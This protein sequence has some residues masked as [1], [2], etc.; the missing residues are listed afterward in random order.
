MIFSSNI[1]TDVMVQT[2]RKSF[3]NDLQSRNG[4]TF[5]LKICGEIVSQ[6]K[7]SGNFNDNFI[8]FYKKLG[9][10]ERDF[11]APYIPKSY[12]DQ[13]IHNVVKNICSESYQSN[14]LN[15]ERSL[16]IHTKSILNELYS[17]SLSV[18]NIRK[19][20]FK[21]TIIEPD[22]ICSLI[23]NKLFTESMFLYLQKNAEDK[24]SLLLPLSYE[25]ENI[26]EYAVKNK[27]K[28]GLKFIPYYKKIIEITEKKES[29]NEDDIND[30]ERSFSYFRKNDNYH[31]CLSSVKQ[32]RDHY[33][34]K[35]KSN[36]F[37]KTPKELIMNLGS[38]YNS[39]FI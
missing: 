16:K 37:S 31:T 24:I 38:V 23:K 12:M 32:V 14:P 34:R 18:K 30:I 19:D 39:H 6:I 22:L 2:M 3:K 13:E 20:V 7:K 36:I 8:N 9:D 33:L 5:D 26:Y 1:D 10:S 25:N 27:V 4:G 29:V 17:I 21:K 15:K 28:D 11:F 35:N